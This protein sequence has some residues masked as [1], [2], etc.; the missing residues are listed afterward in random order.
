MLKHVWIKLVALN[1]AAFVMQ[2][3]FPWFTF[4]FALD[5]KVVF[6]APWMFFTSMFL[7]AGMEHIM[8]NMFALVFFG[9]VAE[10][11]VGS[12]KFITAYIISGLVASFAS[13]LFYPSSISL[14]A[15][16][17]IYGLIGLMTILRPKM[18]VWWGAPI[19][20][21]VFGVLYISMDILG[22]FASANP[23]N[24]AYMA[25]IIGFAVGV[26]FAFRWKDELKEEKQIKQMVDKEFKEEEITDKQLDEWEK[27]YMC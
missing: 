23:D 18:L 24:V 6:D 26:M 15:S 2:L 20:M 1:C 4:L 19:P 27:K 22:V 3:I 14:G 25:H 16:G 9:I 17:A 8:Y 21:V 13:L 12:K 11:T 7:H 5:P 10:Y